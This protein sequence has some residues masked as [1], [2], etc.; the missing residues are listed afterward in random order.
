M[1]VAICLSGNLGNIKRSG[2]RC[3]INKNNL[4]NENNTGLYDPILG[5]NH[6]KK[7]FL[8]KYDTDFFLHC[9]S[10]NENDKQ[11]ILELY[12]PK[13]YIIEKQKIF[14]INL[15]N[16]QI[17]P[18]NINSVFTSSL[19]DNCKSGY[20]LLFD[21]RINIKKWDTTK[22]IDE[23]ERCVFRTSSRL[24]SFNQSYS[25]MKQY[26]TTNNI[27]YDWILFCRFDNFWNLPYNNNINKNKNFVFD[28]NKLNANHAYVER[29]HNRND[30]NNAICDLW[31][32]LSKN[33]VH[34]FNN[35]FEKRFNYCFRCPFYFFKL[36]EETIGLNNIKNIY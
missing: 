31:V 15:N 2:E 19:S 18:S 10:N 30:Y 23:L 1:K 8:D 7:L 6:L 4:K 35:I 16:Y 11:K 33:N 34:T 28:L 27:N 36:L 22:I 24:Y 21:N 29:R 5:Y 17:D 26:E 3:N 32:L 12:K 14:N 25:F 13:K 20:K 9:W